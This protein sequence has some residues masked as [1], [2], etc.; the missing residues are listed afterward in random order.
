MEEELPPPYLE[1]HLRR[2]LA[3]ECVECGRISESRWRGWGAYRVDVPDEAEGP[4]LA[5]YCP[6]CRRQ[7]FGATV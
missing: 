6:E 2:V 5:F 4:E 3:V 1:R 7:H